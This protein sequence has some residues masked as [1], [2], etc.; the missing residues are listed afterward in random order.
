MI[1]LHIHTH[2]S[3]GTENC[4]TVLKKCQEKNLD[5]ISITD[6][7]SV[8]AYFELE[9]LNVKQLYSGKI[10]CGIE[11]NTKIL[12]SGLKTRLK[13]KYGLKIFSLLE[14]HGEHFRLILI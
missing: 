14:M 3:D 7:N 2:Y 13:E 5:Y 1:D 10:I 12:K 11:L 6:H 8:D 4:M 9:K